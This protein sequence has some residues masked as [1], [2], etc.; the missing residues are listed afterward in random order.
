[1]FISQMCCLFPIVLITSLQS[2]S[3]CLQKLCLVFWLICSGVLWSWTQHSCHAVL[4]LTCYT[5]EC[6]LLED[7]D[8]RRALGQNPNV[9]HRFSPSPG[10]MMS[11]HVVAKAVLPDHHQPA[12]Q[13]V[14]SCL[15]AAGERQSDI[16]GLTC[17]RTALPA[18]RRTWC[19]LTGDCHHFEFSR[20][21]LLVNWTAWWMDTRPLAF[22]KKIRVRVCKD[23]FFNPLICRAT[24]TQ[25]WSF[26]ARVFLD[27][28]SLFLSN[29]QF[30]WSDFRAI[31][32]NHKNLCGLLWDSP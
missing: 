1:M 19:S 5:L 14:S 20:S 18:C 24:S 30:Q 22:R 2:L 23:V 7:E 11:Q 15:S 6:F 25:W 4:D 12:P 28:S 31:L 32:N 10:M 13:I 16:L 26:K 3:F 27:F 29:L 9:L 21:S 8:G 17:G